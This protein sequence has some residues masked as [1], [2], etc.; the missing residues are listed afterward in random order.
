[1]NAADLIKT[2][3]LDGVSY[4]IAMC[5]ADKQRAVMFRLGKY[6]LEPAIRNMALAQ[7]GA[8]SVEAIVLGIMGTMMSRMPEEDFNF[9]LD[10]ILYKVRRAGDTNPVTLSDFTGRMQDYTRLAIMALGVNFADFSSFLTLFRKSTT[11]AP[12]VKEETDQPENS[13][14]QSTGSSGDPASA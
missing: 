6:G 4:S 5:P 13:T 2:V 10:T 7:V 3:D 11:E 9:I 1:M 12:A 14:P 8:Q